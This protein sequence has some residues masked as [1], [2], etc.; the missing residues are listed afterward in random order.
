M[1]LKNRQ[2]MSMVLP[3]MSMKWC[4][5]SY[6][7][8]FLKKKKEQVF[9]YQIILLGLLPSHYNG[10]KF[11]LWTSDEAVEKI[12]S[13]NSL[14]WKTWLYYIPLLTL[15]LATPS[16]L[17]SRKEELVW[18]NGLK[19]VQEENTIRTYFLLLL[20]SSDTLVLLRG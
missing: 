1:A 15:S 14:F 4:Q 16:L 2:I 12:Y 5:T 10:T 20:T 3:N 13:L 7:I 18:F 17:S 8:F 19:R 6:I 11:S 9:K